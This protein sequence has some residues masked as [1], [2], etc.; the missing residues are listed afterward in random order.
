MSSQVPGNAESGKI[1]LPRRAVPATRSAK[2]LH[3]PPVFPV[4]LRLLPKSAFPIKSQDD[5]ARKI[6]HLMLDLSPG[7]AMTP[8]TG[9]GLPSAKQPPGRKK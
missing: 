2:P 4:W 1:A 6:S 7:K 3:Q 9:H 8:A 5:L